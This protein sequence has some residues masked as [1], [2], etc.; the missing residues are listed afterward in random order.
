MTNAPGTP[1]GQPRQADPYGQQPSP[2][3]QQQNPYAHQPSPYGQLPAVGATQQY[4]LG[5]QQYAASAMYGTP[6]R[7]P[8]TTLGTWALILGISGFLIPIGLNSIA[9]IVLGIMGIVK[10]QRRGMPI[11]GLSIGAFVLVF[12]MPFIWSVLFALLSLAPL[13]FLPFLY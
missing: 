12:Y 7:S 5:Q 2:Y 11:A 8:R 9:A 13:L 3:G 1:Y 6:P 10:E 4:D